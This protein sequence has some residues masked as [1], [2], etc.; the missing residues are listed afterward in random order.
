MATKNTACSSMNA[1]SD[2][3]MPGNTFAT[4]QIVAS[5]ADGYGFGLSGLSGLSATNR[6]S[7]R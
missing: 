2:E 6:M 4:L 3:S 7:P 5:A 1:R